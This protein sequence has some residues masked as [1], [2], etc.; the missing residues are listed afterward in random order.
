MYRYASSMGEQY[1]IP[2][3]FEDI[4]TAAAHRHRADRLLKGLPG[5]DSMRLETL[6]NGVW[7]PL[8]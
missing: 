1:A 4:L 6:I 3:Y 7:E 2:Q 8:E 5:H